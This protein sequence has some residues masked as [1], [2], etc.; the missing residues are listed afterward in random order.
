MTD[1][2]QVA[3]IVSVPSAL[4]AL[5]TLIVSLRTHGQVVEVKKEMNGMQDK[6][7][8]TTKAAAYAEGVKDEKANPG[9]S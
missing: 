9:A 6:L 8:K 3:L 4:T 2:V 5:G 1:A 7:L